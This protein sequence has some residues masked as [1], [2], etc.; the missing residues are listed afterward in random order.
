MKTN[1]ELTGPQFADKETKF[2]V[3]KLEDITKYL[4]MKDL[5]KLEMICL[6]IK[7]KRLD[8]G[9]ETDPK[10]ICCNQDE[11]YAEVVWQIILYG[12]N[13]KAVK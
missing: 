2:M 4:D 3:L 1:G 5:N 13:M 8:D 12:E 11:P 6:K 9:K 10:Y 7:S